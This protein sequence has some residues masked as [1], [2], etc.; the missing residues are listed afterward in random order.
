MATLLTLNLPPALEEDLIDYLLSLDIL[1]GFTSY[2][3]MGH[4][5]QEN[6]SVAEQVSG[7]RK[8]IQFEI[9]LDDEAEAERIISGLGSEVGKDIRYWQLPVGGIGTT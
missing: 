5:E 2:H 3:A 9:L 1:A 6:L 4:G 7:R 8:R